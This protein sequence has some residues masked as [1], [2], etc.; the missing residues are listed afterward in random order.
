MDRAVERRKLLEQHLQ[1]A[2]L[3]QRYARFPAIDGTAI[4]YGPDA[5]AGSPVLGCTLSHLSIVK[6][7]LDSGKHLHII[8]DDAILHRDIGRVLE[9]F[10]THEQAPEWDVLMTDLFLPP[11]LYLFKYLHEKYVESMKSGTVTFIDIQSWEFAGATSYFVNKDSKEKFLRMMEHGFSDHTPYD[12]RLRTLAKNGML[13]VFTC[14]P[15]FSTLSESSSDSTIAG[16][17]RHVLP[18]S[19]YRRSFYVAAD[20]L[21]IRDKLRCTPPCPSDT[22]TEIYL[23]LIKALLDPQHQSF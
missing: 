16:G 21:G 7:Q 9:H 14:F 10:A 23:N 1:D 6:D 8:E 17:F 11:D 22:H 15:F 3:S 12:I 19:E 4:T 18:L 2:G 5:V 13:K 20:L